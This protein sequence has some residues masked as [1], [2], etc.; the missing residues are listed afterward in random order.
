MI[1]YSSANSGSGFA[2][3]IDI[4]IRHMKNESLEIE[5]GTSQVLGNRPI[6]RIVVTWVT[7]NILS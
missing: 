6:F 1:T 4:E 7:S 5:V 2:L 3:N